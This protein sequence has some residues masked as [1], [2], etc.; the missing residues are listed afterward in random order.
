LELK[1][2]VV[3]TTEESAAGA[4]LAGQSDVDAVEALKAL[5]YSHKEARDA[6]EGI[7]RDIKDPGEK[8][9]A[10]LRVLGTSK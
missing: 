10:A 5:G 8:V 3:Y 6:L 4:G 1:D 9:K 2:K 7:S